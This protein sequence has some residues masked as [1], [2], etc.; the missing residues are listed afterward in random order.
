MPNGGCLLVGLKKKKKVFLWGK[1]KHVII[2]DQ[3][4]YKMIGSE[5]DIKS[6][7]I[8]LDIGMR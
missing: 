2:M 8:L 4:E 3:N 1:G 5:D 7:W 6:R